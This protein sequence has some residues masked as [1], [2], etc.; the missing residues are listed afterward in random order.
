MF[1]NAF[2]D[3]EELIKTIIHEKCHVE[4][5]RK[6]GKKYCQEHLSDMEKEAYNI[7]DEVFE[8]LKKEVK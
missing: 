3:E 5:S 4:H 6:Y 7:Q 2:V 8:R 1:P